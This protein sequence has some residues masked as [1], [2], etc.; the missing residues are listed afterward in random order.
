METLETFTH[1]VAHR[2][3]EDKH[4]KDSKR[5]V[6]WL[7]TFKDNKHKPLSDYKP[8]DIYAFLD[9]LSK[10]IGLA[11]ATLNRYLA[12][13]S[14]VFKLADEW[15]EIAKPPKVKWKP[16]G[17]ERP[18]CFTRE[19]EQ[20]ILTLFRSNPKTTWVADFTVLSINT[21]MRLGEI[22]GI[23]RKLTEAESQ[24]TV[25]ADEFDLPDSANECLGLPK[26]LPLINKGLLKNLKKPYGVISDCDHFVTLSKTKNGEERLVALNS[27]AREALARLNNCPSQVFNH[28]KFYNAWS[29]AREQIAPGD[30]NFAFHVCRHTTAT[31]L[32]MDFN[33]SGLAVGEIM[34]HKSLSTTKKYVHADRDNL[35]NIM[36]RLDTRS[37]A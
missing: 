9:H 35:T 36:N 20:A 37:V 30:M 11:D 34:G 15:D 26:P 32:T 6:L 25:E 4:L 17:S 10:D 8:V 24:R 7:A 31:R 12:A 29:K 2:L 14:C 28:R 22:L 33:T 27:A 16:S 1:K 23:N 13:F 5:K 21:G 18:R 19:E 3:W